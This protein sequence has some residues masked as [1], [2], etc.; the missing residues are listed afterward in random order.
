M[1]ITDE[2]LIQSF[3]KDKKQ[4]IED[5]GFTRKVIAHLPKRRRSRISLIS[6]TLLL[7][8]ILG[9][10]LYYTSYWEELFNSYFNIIYNLMEPILDLDYKAL[11]LTSALLLL[12]YCLDLILDSN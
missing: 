12:A 5:N 8:I 3:L 1:K 11:V 10:I 4:T 2:Q 9:V 6:I 7:S